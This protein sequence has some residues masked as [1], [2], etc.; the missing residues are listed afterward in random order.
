MKGSVLHEERPC[1]HEHIKVT[2][3]A[4]KLDVLKLQMARE[5]SMS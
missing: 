2:C 4:A 1:V 3:K 5:I